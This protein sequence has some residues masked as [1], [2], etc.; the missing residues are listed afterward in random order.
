MLDCIYNIYGISHHLSIIE[1]LCKATSYLS[2][3]LG[4]S[5][6]T[7]SITAFVSFE[8]ELTNCKT[9]YVSITLA[10][11]G[12]SNFTSLSGSVSSGK[13]VFYPCTTMLSLASI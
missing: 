7:G 11:Y 13:D 12:C 4:Y 10:G 3:F 9:G 5:Y 1:H 8:G 6:C 2:S